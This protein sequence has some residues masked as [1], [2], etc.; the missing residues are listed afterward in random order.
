MSRNLNDLMLEKWVA[1]SEDERKTWT[2][3]RGL[4]PELCEILQPR[5]DESCS[6]GAA[7]VVA[8]RDRY[9]EALEW[10]TR[11]LT[12]A[13]TDLNGNIAAMEECEGCKLTIQE[14]IHRATNALKGA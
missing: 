6:E 4:F 8:E 9:R 5:E 2:M 11:N 10:I 7:R 13:C 1:M 12:D 14:V 3:Q